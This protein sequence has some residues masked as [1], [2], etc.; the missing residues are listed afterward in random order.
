MVDSD[1]IFARALQAEEQSAAE[2]TA[3]AVAE[4]ERLAWSL[5]DP[6]S[7]PVSCADATSPRTGHVPPSPP[8]SPSRV[9]CPALATQNPYDILTSQSR[10]VDAVLVRE[11]ARTKAVKEEATASFRMAHAATNRAE[12]KH[13]R[14]VAALSEG[15]G[16][17][18]RLRHELLDLAAGR[19][20][21]D[22]D[23]LCDICTKI[24]A[25][26][27]SNKTRL[28]ASRTSKRRVSCLWNMSWRRNE[29]ITLP[30][31]VS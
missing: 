9:A 5:S 3:A 29:Q 24:Y 20:R 1:A 13:Q 11:A 19:K 23:C 10:Q 14:A 26:K 28:N 18:R 17:E 21:A 2:K 27:P 6:N 31:P 25:R 7:P 12:R 16:E 15:Q 22:A 8:D 30:L 4:D